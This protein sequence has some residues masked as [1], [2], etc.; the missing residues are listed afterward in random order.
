VVARVNAI[1]YCFATEQEEKCTRVVLSMQSTNLHVV[2]QVPSQ[3]ALELFKSRD[4]SDIFT[5]GGDVV[6]FSPWPSLA[7]SLTHSRHKLTFLC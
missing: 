2:N 7:V 4:A 1:S 3:N 6:Q 5:I